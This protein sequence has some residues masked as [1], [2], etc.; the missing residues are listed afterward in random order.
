[1]SGGGQNIY[2]LRADGYLLGGTINPTVTPIRATRGAFY[3]YVAKTINDPIGLLQKL[4]NGCTTNWKVVS[5]DAGIIS[6][7]QGG[8]NIYSLTFNAVNSRVLIPN[9]IQYQNLGDQ[10]SV[11]CWVKTNSNQDM[12]L[13][14]QYPSSQQ[15]QTFRFFLD[16]GRPRVQLR[17]ANNQNGQSNNAFVPNISNGQWRMA[18]FTY[19]SGVIKIYVDGALIRSDTINNLTVLRAAANNV[20]VF[21]GAKQNNASNTGSLTQFYDGLMDNMAVFQA[22]LTDGDMLDFYNKFGDGIQDEPYFS[23]CIGYYRFNEP[24]QLPVIVDQSFFQ[25]DG[26]GINF[27]EADFVPDIPS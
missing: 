4:D 7:G 6:P 23:S 25:F 8:P 2:N 27:V 10:M 11:A 19:D 18:G 9:N 1:M 3:I 24:D 20:P 22:A 12:G 15:Q 13:I 26:D 16:S 17:G 14:T 5:T 21:I